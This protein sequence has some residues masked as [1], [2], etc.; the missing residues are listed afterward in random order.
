M[1]TSTIATRRDQKAWL[2]RLPPYRGALHGTVHSLSGD[3][4]LL[5]S[6][7]V[8]FKYVGACLELIIGY[9]VSGLD[10]LSPDLDPDRVLL[11]RRERLD[12]SGLMEYSTTAVGEEREAGW[13]SVQRKAD[14]SM[15]ALV[16]EGEGDIVRRELPPETLLPG[17]AMSLLLEAAMR[18]DD[19]APHICL[20]PMDSS[21]AAMAVS[22]ISPYEGQL[23]RSGHAAWTFVTSHVGAS[24][25]P[26][27]PEV[28]EWAVVRD[29]GVL[30]ACSLDMPDTC[31][32]FQLLAPRTTN[33]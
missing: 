30:L 20:H 6:G 13:I 3:M 22:C 5:T 7:Y 25:S 29:D 28:L 27:M 19:E 10:P 16:D 9:V 11:I 14:G 12:G 17:E 26:E 18:G 8:Q 32:S 33:H 23:N 2:S 31:W 15:L 1:T 4:D 21:H 24:C